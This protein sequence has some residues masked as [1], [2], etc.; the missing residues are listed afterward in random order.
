MQDEILQFNYQSRDE[1][2]HVFLGGKQMFKKKLK[3]WAASTLVGTLL[4]P[5]LIGCGTNAETSESV[6]SQSAVLETDTSSA[7]ESD[8]FDAR[9]ITEGVKLTICVADNIKVEDFNTNEMTLAVEEALGV[10]LEFIVLPSADYENKLNVML[11]GGDELPDIIFNAPDID[12][13]GQ[14]GAFIPLNKYYEDPNFSENIRYG[15]ETTGV[16]IPL[17]LTATDGNIYALP[18]YSQSYNGEVYKKLWVY[19]PWLEQ[20]GKEVPETTEE[21]LEIMELVATTDLNGNGKADEIGLTGYGLDTYFEC[22]MSSFIYA[23]D[24]NYRVLEDGKISFAYTSDKWKEGLKYIKELFDNKSIPFETLTQAAE[25]YTALLNAED[26]T[27]FA[28]AGWNPGNVKDAERRSGYTYINALEGPDGLKEAMFLPNLPNR[29]AAISV[30]CEN[31][32]A[33]FLVCDYL[34][35]E[36][37]AITQRYGKRGVDWDYFE[38]ANIENKDAYIATVPGFDIS[39]IAYDDVNFWGGTTPQNVSYLQVGPQ[40]MWVG[41]VNG[42][43]INAGASTPEEKLAFDYAQ[44]YASSSVAG[45][46]LARSADEV[47]SY[48][49]LLPEEEEIITEPLSTMKNYVKQTTAEFLTGERDI[50]AEWDAY[51]AELKKMGIDTVVE[52]LQGAYDRLYK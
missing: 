52:T 32:D 43:A 41:I 16:D 23:Y 31:P 1:K 11:T 38:E 19:T 26:T 47:I 12:R 50:D 18:A 10:D 48:L 2:Q 8:V 33:A 22:L 20:L 15:M 28:L 39:I 27:V 13:W 46:E 40:V 36:E 44:T 29:G 45:H 21:F 14:E 4:V 30:D 7:S 24:S 9:S 5:T 25:Q 51:L 6:A 34:C 37:F 42:V 35:K 17:Y 49:P 3:K